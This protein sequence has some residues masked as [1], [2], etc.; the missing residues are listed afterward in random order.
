MI[1]PGP[2]NSITDVPGIQ[3]GQARD[4][5][6]ISGVTVVCPEEAAV[7]AVD[8]RGGGPGTRETDA[9]KPENLVDATHAVVLSGGSAMGLDAAGGVGSVFN[10]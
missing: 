9:L 4:E 2:R 5:A 10:P 1:K 6:L 7:T 8:C 3:V